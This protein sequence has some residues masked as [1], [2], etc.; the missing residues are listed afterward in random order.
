[1]I[2]ICHARFDCSKRFDDGEAFSGYTAYNIDIPSTVPMTL[3]L[4]HV[5]FTF[6]TRAY[7]LPLLWFWDKLHFKKPW[8]NM[9][10]H[11]IVD[12]F[13]MESPGTFDEYRE[14]ISNLETN[15]VISSEFSVVAIKILVV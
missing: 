2:A 6:F 5:H 10:N 1:M 9:W 15:E 14:P 3:L 12:L 4:E 11:F 7:L 13:K 8:L